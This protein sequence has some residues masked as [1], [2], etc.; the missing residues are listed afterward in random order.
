[1]HA[2]TSIKKHETNDTIKDDIS[3]EYKNGSVLIQKQSLSLN[4][5]A[6]TQ[7]SNSRL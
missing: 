5:Y 2:S 4:L 1:M 6:R 3:T 7:R